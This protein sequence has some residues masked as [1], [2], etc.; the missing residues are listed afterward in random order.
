MRRPDEDEHEDLRAYASVF[1]R[2]TSGSPPAPPK[3]REKFATEA[4]RR[5][6]ALGERL[7]RGTHVFGERLHRHSDALGERLRRDT[8]ALG[9]R[10][11]RDG[12]SFGE[13]VRR[14]VGT[15]GERFRRGTG[16]LGERVRRGTGAVDERLRQGTRVLLE[17]GRDERASFVGRMRAMRAWIGNPM[18]RLRRPWA[19][20]QPP[21]LV[22]HEP[23]IF[24]GLASFA[25]AFTVAWWTGGPTDDVRERREAAF[26]AEQ[27]VPAVGAPLPLAT[28][29]Q[30][31]AWDVGQVLRT[32]GASEAAQLAVVDE[33]AKDSG[34][35]AT[36]ALIAGVDSG[37]LHVSMACLRA[38]SGRSCDKV[39]SDLARRLEDPQWERRAWAARVLGAND[40]AGAGRRLMERLAVEPDLRVQAQ[41]QLAI[42]S[43]KEPG[44]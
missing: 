23:S 16:A 3:R 34:D 6:L 30:P 10:L 25:F 39:A 11:R 17:R 35:D 33:L 36:R 7:R 41:I 21:I 29:A 18:R 20:A 4:R 2:L 12:D 44:A 13:R 19:S 43:L 26:V 38:L 24:V 22:P 42:D 31:A 15:F 1:A 9:E 27:A 32:P 37:S 8:E 14:D 28:S 40:C 5:V